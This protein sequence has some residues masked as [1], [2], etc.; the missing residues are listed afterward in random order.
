[1]GRL[2]PAEGD[3]TLCAVYV[4][5]DDE[6]GLARRVAPLRIGGRLAPVWPI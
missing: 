3:A 5:T 2:E 4:E 6:T 1:T